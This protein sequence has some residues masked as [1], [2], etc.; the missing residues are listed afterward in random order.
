MSL[1]QN[2]LSSIPVPSYFLGARAQIFPDYVD[3]IDGGV[4]I[5]DPSLGLDYQIWTAEIISDELAD[6]IVLSAPTHPQEVVYSGADITEVSL[7]FNQS[8]Q[9]CIAFVEQGISKVLW[10]DTY[11]YAMTVTEIGAEAVNPKV[12]L[13]DNREFNRQNSDV[14]LAYIKNGALYYRQ[15][16]DRFG[17]ERQLSS[18]PW[19]ALK[20]IGMGAAMRFQF[21]VVAP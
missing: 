15:Q 7:A 2:S 3:Y 14:I 19:I 11:I 10:Y 20:R 17:V 12:A 6:S 1:P 5:Q 13:D 18:G 8:M 4:G 9:L 16:R 21:Q